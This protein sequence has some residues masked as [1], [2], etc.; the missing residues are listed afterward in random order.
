MVI[1]AGHGGIDGGSE[2]SISKVKESK[3]NLEI[4]VKLKKSLEK[5]GFIVIMTRE[6]DVGLYGDTSDGFKVRDLKK[7]VQIINENKPDLAV[8]IHLNKYSKEYRRGAQVF[9]SKNNSIS[10]NLANDIQFYLNLLKES[11]KMYDALIGDYYILNNS[12]SPAVIVECGFLSNNEEEKLLQESSYQTKL[13]D[14][15]TN[16]I[17]KFLST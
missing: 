1:D 5:V 12:N 6:S 2:G 3:L 9:Y 4:A 16:G 15:I 17:L 13:A 10:K 8:S 14:A 11:K 7:R